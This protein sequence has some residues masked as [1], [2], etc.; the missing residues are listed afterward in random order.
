MA[1]EEAKDDERIL[2]MLSARTPVSDFLGNGVLCR[3]DVCT[4]SVEATGNLENVRTAL[5][6]IAALED[7]VAAEEAPPAPFSIMDGVSPE[8]EAAMHDQGY[9]TFEDVAR[10]E[11]ASL[12]L[13]EFQLGISRTLALYIRQQARTIFNTPTLARQELGMATAPNQ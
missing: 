7:Q 4:V 11:D 12:Q 5:A 13:V 8:L 10:W 2:F 3:E 9:L 6:N 1:I